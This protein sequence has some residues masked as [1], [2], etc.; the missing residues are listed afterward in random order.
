WFE[1]GAWGGQWLKEQVKDLN[2][3][4]VNYAWSFEMIVPENGI[5]FESDGNLLEL[6]FDFLMFAQYQNILG[7]HA[8]TFKTEFPIRFDFLD[9]WDGGNLSIQ[10][11]P[12][13]NYIRKE[14]GENLTQDETYYILDCKEDAQVYLGFQEDIDPVKFRKALEDSQEHKQEIDIT[15]YVQMHDAAKHDLF[16]IPNG[17]VHSAGSNNLVLEISA[18]PY[19]FTFKMYDW[20]R[21]DLNGEPRPINIDHAFNNL[22]FERKGAV[23]TDTLIS[24]QSVINSGKDWELV[25]LPTHAAQF[26]DIHRVEFDTEVTIET[27]NGCISVFTQDILVEVKPEIPEITIN[28]PA[29]CLNDVMK[30][31]VPEQQN[32]SYAWSGPN[33]F[34]ATTSSI[35]IP[36]INFNQAGEYRIVLTSG[37]CSSDPATITVP[38]IANVP[39]A[40]FYTEPSFNVKFSVPAPV[41]FVN[42]SKYGDYFEWNFGDG[43]LSSEKNPIHTYQ[44][45]GTFQITLT[46]FSNNGCSNSVTQGDII[47]RKEVSIFTPNAF[48]PNG[49]GVND[50]FVVGITNLK[51]YRIQIYNRYG[52]QVFFTD[53]IFDNW[54]GTFKNNDLPTGVYYYVIFGTHLNNTTVKYTGSVT[55]LR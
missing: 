42:T 31:S 4:E 34:T 17:T 46:A 50:E 35:E 30:L 9:T 55:L 47:I 48:S 28:Q 52:S 10:C 26:Y 33:N 37:T 24:K 21:L 29:F 43:I 22:N 16:L 8:N 20:L 51:R 2:K 11:H 13:L 45:D 6:S 54:K 23:V 14:F 39:I 40:S 12:S 25:H 27:N 1:A 38:P 5:V 15:E 32:M 49:D 19:I 41:S 3:D 7:K 53:N 18:T 36:V 44:T